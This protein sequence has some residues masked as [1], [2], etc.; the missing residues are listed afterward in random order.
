M[1]FAL[2]LAAKVRPRED[3][4][5]D[6]QHGNTKLGK[7]D[8]LW[9]WDLPAVTTCPGRSKLCED[10]C[11]ANSGFF[12]MPGTTMG[13]AR[14]LRYSHGADFE[15][16]LV[17][18]LQKRAVQ[19]LRVH[20]SG[21]FYSQAYAI[22]CWRVFRRLPHTAF[23]FYTRSWRDREILPVLAGM[24]LEPNVEAWFSTDKETGPP[25]CA[26]PRV[27]IAYMLTAGETAPAFPVDLVF[28]DEDH[29]PGQRV[30]RAGGALVCPYEQGPGLNV[31]C[32]RCKICF[33]EALRGRS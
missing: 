27:K 17:S 13:L 28:R 30:K 11:Y 4:H 33:R 6:I 3:D 12:R 23:Y 29:L 15:D 8:I 21:D 25:E 7:K 16:W 18:V 22:S 26:L 20:G 2:P 9:V 5:G 14:N 1:P 10:L 19:V 24:A 31:T 32:A